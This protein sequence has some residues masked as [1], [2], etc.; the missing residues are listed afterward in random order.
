MPYSLSFVESDRLLVAQYN[1]QW[2]LDEA[3]RYVRDLEAKM[4]EIL[5]RHKDFRF[6]SD[7]TRS[8]VQTSE[9]AEFLRSY[10]SSSLRRGISRSAVITSNTLH[11]LQA[12]RLASND[13]MRFFTDRAEA[14]AWLLAD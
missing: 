13:T 5:Q 6:L 11:K 4:T 2:T 9:V 3:K 1:R 8:G 12:Q 7:S 14:M 10:G